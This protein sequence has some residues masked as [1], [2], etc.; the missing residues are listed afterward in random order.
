MRPQ[1][2][3]LLERTDRQDQQIVERNGIGLLERVFQIGIDASHGRREGVACCAGVFAWR[4]ECI[5]G[6]R[7]RTKNSLWRELRGAELATLHNAFDGTDGVVF[8]VDREVLLASHD[9]RDA[10]QEAGPKGVER[11]APHAFGFVPEELG[12]AR[13]HLAGRLVR[14]RHRQDFVGCHAAIADEPGDA[15]GQYPGLAGARAG[16]HE[17][18]PVVMEYGL[19]LARIE[20]SRQ[21][22]E[23]EHRCRGCRR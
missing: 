12:N 6:T 15:R 14:E 3:V 16:E 20:A 22:L 7:D 11:T 1:G 21:R 2:F 18:G 17:G 4:N 23:I 8:V 19:A 10:A 13:P 5:L 9:R